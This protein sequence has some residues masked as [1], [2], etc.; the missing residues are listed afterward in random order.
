MVINGTINSL[1]ASLIYELNL[2]GLG[3]NNIDGIEHFTNLESLSCKNNNLTSIPDLPNQ[4]KTL[5]LRSNNISHINPLPQSVIDV[6]LRNNSLTSVP[7][8]PNQIEILKLCFNNFSNIP[9]LPDSLKVLYFVI[10]T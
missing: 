4:L 3:L 5:N 10:I 6:D 2:D 7:E 1:E 8:F 9:N